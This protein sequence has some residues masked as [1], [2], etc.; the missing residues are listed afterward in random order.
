[1]AKVLG[2]ARTAGEFK[3]QEAYEQLSSGNKEKFTDYVRVLLLAQEREE[4]LL[5]SALKDRRKKAAV[6][7]ILRFSEMSKEEVLLEVGELVM[8]LPEE[9]I[10]KII[11]DWETREE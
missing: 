8:N 9:Q 5:I 2:K 11:Q 7:T 10:E 6:A 1:M 3:I 4:W